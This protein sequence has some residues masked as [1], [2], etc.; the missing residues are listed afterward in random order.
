MVESLS[1]SLT[2]FRDS[3]FLLEETDAFLSLDDSIPPGIDDGTYDSEGDILFLERL[4]NDDPTPDLPPISYPVCL[5]NDA[6]K[7]KSSIDDPLD[8]NL[9]DLPSHLEYAFLEGTFKLPII[10]TKDLKKE[11]KEQLLKRQGKISQRGM[12]DAAKILFWFVR[13]LTSRASISWGRSRLEEGTD[14]F[15]WLSIMFQ[16]WLRAKRTPPNTPSILQKYGVTHRLSTSYHSNKSNVWLLPSGGSNKKV[17]KI[18]RKDDAASEM[19]E[20]QEDA[21]RYRILRNG[22]IKDKNGQIRARE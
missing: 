10:I 2:P 17:K 12:K 18:Y 1:P 14:I 20:Q 13:F 19:A 11:E 16:K 4:L 8:L 21:M 9:K 5:I 3:N 7:I 6:K 22:Q 15:S